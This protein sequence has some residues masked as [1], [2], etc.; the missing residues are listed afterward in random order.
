[1]MMMDDGSYDCDDAGNK[2]EVRGPKQFLYIR[3]FSYAGWWFQ[4]FEQL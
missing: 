2:D 3:F 4:K 1:M